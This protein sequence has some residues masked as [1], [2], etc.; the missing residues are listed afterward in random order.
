M[1]SWEGADVMKQ[2]NLA[3]ALAGIAALGLTTVLAASPAL[4]N[5]Y[6]PIAPPPGGELSQQ[7]IMD[8]VYGGTF[9]Q[10][11]VDY[12]NG[13]LTM[14]RVWDENAGSLTLDLLTGDPAV[15]VDQVWTDGIAAVT[16]QAMY[17]DLGQTFGWNGGGATGGTYNQL[18]TDADIGGPGVPIAVSGDMLWGVKPTSGDQF[19]SRDSENADGSDHLI[20]Y[21]ISGHGGPETRW[22]TFWE[23]LPQGSSDWDYNDFVVEIAAVPEPGTALLIGLGLGL[24]GLR[25][26]G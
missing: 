14:T 18:L 25:R 11:G 3:R 9:V 8:L 16:A 13:V 26:R 7:E 5:S 6:T 15:D 24:M 20:T 21:L 23:D 19:W 2:R 10:S 1:P 17:A 4:A 12:S 22:L